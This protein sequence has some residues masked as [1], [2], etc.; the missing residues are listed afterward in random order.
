MAITFREFLGE[1]NMR[2]AAAVGIAAQIRSLHQQITQDKMATKIE[3]TLSQEIVWLAEPA[4]CGET[5]S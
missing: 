2:S 4:P 3:K 1:S 5:N